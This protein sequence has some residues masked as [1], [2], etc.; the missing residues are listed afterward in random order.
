MTENFFDLQRFADDTIGYDTVSGE[1]VWKGGGSF[2]GGDGSTSLSPVYLSAEGAS[3]IESTVIWLTGGASSTD[4]YSFA[5]NLTADDWEVA[6]GGSNIVGGDLSAGDGAYHLIGNVD[7]TA[8]GG[9]SQGF[10]ETVNGAQAYV[11]AAGSNDVTFNLAADGNSTMTYT[12]AGGTSN[13]AVALDENDTAI[14]AGSVENVTFGTDT[15]DT[16]TPDVGPMTLAAGATV[17]AADDVISIATGD[18]TVTDAQGT[19]MEIQAASSTATL[20]S[21]NVLSGISS[22]TVTD[23]VEN[24]TVN[25]AAWN[26]ING[27]I[28]HVQFD[29]DGNAHIDNTGSVTV[30]GVADNRAEFE[31]L[32]TVGVVVND[33]TIQ[34][35][36]S[37]ETT[38]AAILDET[39][40]KSIDLDDADGAVQ[41]SGDS[42]FEVVNETSAYTINTSASYVGFDDSTVQPE[43]FV[44]GGEA[45]TVGGAAVAYSFGDTTGTDVTINGAGVDVSNILVTLTSSDVSKGIDTVSGLEID[46]TVNVTDDSDGY[47]AIF[48][49]DNSTGDLA[50]NDLKISVEDLDNAVTMQIDAAG[51]TAT[52]TGLEADSAVTLSGGASSATTYYIRDASIAKNKVTVA[53]GDNIVIGLDSIGNVNETVDGDT[54]DKVIN[55]EKKW[56][57][58]STLGSAVDTVAAHHG[59]LYD[60]DFYTLSD[61]SAAG[62]TLAG[63]ASDD[64]TPSAASSVINLT[65]D[66]SLGSARHV[67]LAIGSGSDAGKIP[68]NIE[69]NENSDVVDVTLDLTKSNTPSTVIVGSVSDVTAAHIIKISD[70]GG[71]VY[72]GDNALGQNLVQAGA[73]GANLRHDGDARTTLLGGAGSDT[74][75]GDNYDFIQGGAGTDYFVDGAGYTIQDYSADIDGDVVVAMSLSSLDEVTP[76]SISGKSNRVGFGGG[77]KLTFGD[78]TDSALHVRVAL[79]D[80]D[81]DI[82]GS[83]TRDVFLAGDG[84]TVDASTAS[85]SGALIITAGTRGDN[86]NYVTGSAGRD[87]IYAGSGD[88]I[89]GGDGNDYIEI[90]PTADD[91]TIVILSNGRD[92]VTGWSFGFERD[93]GNN[94]L[95]VGGSSFGAKV[96]DDMLAVTV[97]GGTILFTDTAGDSSARNLLITTGSEDL[98]YTVIRSGGSATVSSDDDIADGYVALSDGNL[99]FTSAVTK[100]LDINLGDNYQNIR[101]LTVNNSGRASIVGSSSRETV[102]VGTNS[103]ADTKFVSLGGGNDV[104]NSNGTAGL[105]NAIF[106]SAGDGHDVVNNFGHYNGIS[107]DPTKTQSDLIVVN[108]FTDLSVAT[109]DGGANITFITSDGEIVIRESSGISDTYDSAMYRVKINGNDEAV[110][111]IGSGNGGNNFTYSDEVAYYMGA[112]GTAANTLTVSEGTP[113]VEVWLDNG[114]TNQYRGIGVVDG[115]GVVGT[116]I[117][118]A[119]SADNNTLLGADNSGATSHLWGGAGDN[120]LVGG[121]GNDTFYYFKNSRDYVRD[122]SGLANA[123]RDTISGYDVDNDTI[124]LGDITVD[125]INVTSMAAKSNGIGDEAVTVEFNNGGSLTVNTTTNARFTTADGTTYIAD[126]TSKQWATA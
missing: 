71:T 54:A 11:K 67:T 81:G 75:Q 50:A 3:G 49:A 20:T 59:R 45:Y 82:D 17:T 47:T 90:E 61:G 44:R 18:N 27:S 85:I 124:L 37:D 99:E 93:E 55:Y 31:V 104:F 66:T 94:A 52:V 13:L 48:S 97:D 111:K 84:Q 125:D 28:S 83:N 26:L 118:L 74:I 102:N 112:A 21:D 116:K 113:N 57:A 109:V 23:T 19:V 56:E 110:A 60:E 46:D 77:S 33:A 29:G 34:A 38:F 123:N 88:S 4:S 10:T 32:P 9:A 87:S 15:A 30:S 12:F 40:I 14:F 69:A 41:I 6:I 89:D 24:F 119:G 64:A 65:G 103:A 68:I 101:N 86:A 115:R 72:I 126:R 36:N 100:D 76:D 95:Y 91:G 5:V 79:L 105:T 80:D 39:G 1:F 16:D 98:K 70:A 108:D 42:S 92:S 107:S 51:T 43:I 120:S 22:A 122:A 78:D 117:T 73:T 53:A 106:F 96:V 7:I 58:V 35:I 121:A 63:Y 114:D 62:M 8:Y 25:G 2:A